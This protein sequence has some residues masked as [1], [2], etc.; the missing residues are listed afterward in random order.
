MSA[1]DLQ[2]IVAQR[3]FAPR[4]LFSHLAHDHVPFDELTGTE[5]YESVALRAVQTEPVC[6]TV[7]G[8]VGGGKSSLIAHTCRHLAAT[9]VALRVPVTGADDPTSVSVVAAAALSQALY[10]V[11]LEQYQREALDRARADTTIEDAA[12]STAV[13]GKLGGGPIPAE[14]QAELG[15]L[16]Q[17]FQR[18]QLAGDRLTGLDRLVTILVARGLQPVFV[19]EDTEAAVGSDA[20]LSTIDA[21]FSGPVRAFM[22]EVEASCLLAVQDRFTS[23]SAFNELAP[24]MQLIEV[25]TLAGDQLRAA[26]SRIVSHRL[27]QVELATSVDDVLHPEVLELVV[28]FYDETDG[29]LRHVLAALQS[30]SEYA[31]DTDANRIGPGHIRAAT[32]DWRARFRPS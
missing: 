7:I 16:R 12:P 1:R 23:C 8:P 10:D 5:Q 26:L 20:D 25:P 24:S 9:H 2:T 19:L 29:S 28:S 21:F 11:E 27:G 13:G 15:T 18:N 14:V 31:N 32:D 3:A 22:N 30:A 4:R 17:Q 6:V